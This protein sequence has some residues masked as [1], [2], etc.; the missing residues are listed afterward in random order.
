[1]KTHLFNKY[2]KQ[3]EFQKLFNWRF[4]LAFGVILWIVLWLVS[5]AVS[6]LRVIAAVSIILGIADLTMF[7]IKKGKKPKN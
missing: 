6:L 5:F 7:I 2:R 4:L 3:N 1:M